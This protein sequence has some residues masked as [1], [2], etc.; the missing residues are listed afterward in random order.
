MYIILVPLFYILRVQLRRTVNGPNSKK[1]ERKY[2]FLMQLT[3]MWIYC[4]SR[5]NRAR[6]FIG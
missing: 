2:E 6:D 1:K 5:I 3:E 4:Y